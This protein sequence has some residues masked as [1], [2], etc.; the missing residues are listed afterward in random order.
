MNNYIFKLLL[1]LYNQNL[2]TNTCRFV[3]LF[4]IF[5][6]RNDSSNNP[7]RFEIPFT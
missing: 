5:I 3:K 1:D 6:P 7:S 2:L 4:I